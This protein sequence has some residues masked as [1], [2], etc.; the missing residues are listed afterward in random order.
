MSEH[1]IG[2]LPDVEEQPLRESRC[3]RCGAEPSEEDIARQKLSSLGYLHDDQ[4][5]Q[6]PECSHKY[7]HGVPQGVFD[8]DADDLWCEV[9]ELGFMRVHRVRVP[10]DIRPDEESDNGSGASVGLDLKCHHHHDFECPHCHGTVP[11]DGTLAAEAGGGFCPHCDSEIARSE[12]P[13]CYYF[14][15]VDR[16]LGRKGIS[17]VG[18]PTI[19]GRLNP[20]RPYGFPDDPG[21]SG[22]D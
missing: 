7:T 15:Q 6:C 3:P 4:T 9:C 18:F 8:G 14:K 17:L 5:F 20:G 10:D 11:A 12:I 22:E 1:T 2:E 13:Y 21:N 19:T 16:Q